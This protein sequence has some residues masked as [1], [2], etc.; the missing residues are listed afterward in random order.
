MTAGPPRT[1]G[2]G[3]SSP[4][5]GH[6]SVTFRS[7]GSLYTQRAMTD[8]D[9]RRMVEAAQRDPSRFGD[10]YERHFN[11]VYAFVV[12]RVRDRDVAED[13]TSDVFQKA[14]ANLPAYQWRGAPFGAWLIRIAANA[15]LDRSKRAGREVVD[16]DRLP[17]VGA[18]PDL[19]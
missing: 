1:S 4:W 13:V 16:S 18:E 15:V 7:A 10:L 17:D 6:R 3:S 14:L 12:R 11:R 2:Q 5:S 19:D 9:E 8:A